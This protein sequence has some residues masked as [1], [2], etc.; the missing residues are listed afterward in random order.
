MATTFFFLQHFLQTINIKPK[1]K[2]LHISLPIK[3]TGFFQELEVGNVVYPFFRPV[4]WLFLTPDCFVTVSWLLRILMFF[5]LLLGFEPN[6]IIGQILV[7]PI[8]GK[9]GANQPLRLR[10]IDS[11]RKLYLFDFVYDG[12]VTY[13]PNWIRLAKRSGFPKVVHNLQ[14]QTRLS[15]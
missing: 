10:H 14:H 7:L 5:I 1:S 13:C 11:R 15:L 9:E 12:H 3:T 8:N 6:P 2:E 4:P